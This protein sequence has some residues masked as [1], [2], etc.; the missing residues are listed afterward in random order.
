MKHALPVR[1]MRNLKQS[2]N[3]DSHGGRKRAAPQGDIREVARQYLA[4]G[5]KVVP[6]LNGKKHP[7]FKDW[8]LQ[9]FTPE[10]FGGEYSN[11]GLQFGPMSNDLCDIDLDCDEGRILAPYFLP[12][13][14]AVFGRQSAPA[15]H[16]LYRCDAWKRAE[17]AVQTFDDPVRLA[18]GDDTDHGVR[19]VELRTGR[20]RKDGVVIGALSMVPPSVHPSGEV[21]RWDREGEPAQVDGAVIERCVATLAAATMLVRHYPPKGQR[22]EAM[23]VLGGWLARAGW[24]EDRIEH[25]IGAV[26]HTAGDEEWSERIKSAKSAVRKLAEGKP[27]PGTP[28]MRQIFGDA[29]GNKLENWLDIDVRHGIPTYRPDDSVHI[30]PDVG[31]TLDDFYAH[32]PSHKYIFAPSRDPWPASSVNARIPPVR[33]GNDDIPASRW[34]DQHHAVEQITWGPGMPMLIRDR[35]IAEGG[36]IERKGVTCFNLYRPPTI[37]AGDANKAGPWIDH[38]NMVYPDDAEHITSYLAHRVQRPYEKINHALVLGGRQGIGKDT[39]LEP[40][41]YA[42]GPWNFAEVSPQQ[43]I[44][45]F[46]GFLKSAILRVSEA[47]DLGEVNRFKLY[48]HLKSYTAAPPDVLQS[49]RKTPA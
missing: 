35:L 33:V 1:A 47:R 6:I 8:Q 19:L 49:R 16:W 26:A 2:A 46:N 44:G 48:D 4:L 23:L 10:N 31:V 32:M 11:I 20:V 40:V 21:V 30:Q 43:L 27:I 38:V 36:W 28:R 29:I 25:F 37:K 41:K 15:S 18:S 5:L 12:D 7:N 42:V 34:L 39:L 13:T 14:A 17:S 3:M 9:S 45:R 22:H 24:A